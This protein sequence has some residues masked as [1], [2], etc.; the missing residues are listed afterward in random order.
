MPGHVSP[1]NSLRA[2]NDGLKSVGAVLGPFPSYEVTPTSSA[3]RPQDRAAARLRSNVTLAPCWN[4]VPGNRLVVGC[5]LPRDMQGGG[6]ACLGRHAGG[7]DGFSVSSSSPPQ[8]VSWRAAAHANAGSVGGRC[9]VGP[10]RRTAMVQTYTPQAAPAHKRGGPYA[11][12]RGLPGVPGGSLMAFL[13]L[14]EEALSRGLSTFGP[15]YAL[16][17]P[18]P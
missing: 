1:G 8:A 17:N 18:P 7:G 13:W 2:S 6:P 3:A 9:P 16:V 5:L 12:P 14:L 10:P 4:L 15:A 11:S